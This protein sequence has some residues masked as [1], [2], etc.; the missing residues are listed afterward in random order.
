MIQLSQIKV[1]AC[2]PVFALATATAAFAGWVGYEAVRTPAPR[3]AAEVV[4]EGGGPGV[5]TH[6][7]LL[8]LHPGM[9]RGHV[10]QLLAAVA[11]SEPEYAE[12]PSAMNSGRVQYVVRLDA[13]VPHLFPAFEPRN[14]RPGPHRLTLEFDSRLP[15]QPL[16]AVAL[17][18][19]SPE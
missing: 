13:P 16:C 8:Q 2:S 7:V 3:R 12:Y 18:P 10:E 4:R 5:P 15:A 17:S 9:A 11:V 19:L 1:A 6:M 14:F